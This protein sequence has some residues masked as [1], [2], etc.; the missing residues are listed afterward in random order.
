[1][2]D[3]G[4]KLAITLQI[5]LS[6][7]GIVKFHESSIGELESGSDPEDTQSL[8]SFRSLNMSIGGSMLDGVIG[9]V[10]E[11]LGVESHLSSSR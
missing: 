1:M 6:I 8:R 11:S 9:H 7:S 10:R 2:T 4:I 3:K 5:A